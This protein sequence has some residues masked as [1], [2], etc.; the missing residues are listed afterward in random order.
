MYIVVYGLVNILFF[1]AILHKA[2]L[3]KRKAPFICITM[4]TVIILSQVVQNA[5]IANDYHATKTFITT[6]TL[7]I[8][9]HLA[10]N[11][12]KTSNG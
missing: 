8:L 1:S 11:P 2:A 7:K 10:Q 12:A 6:E 9:L 5:L 4:A 3:K